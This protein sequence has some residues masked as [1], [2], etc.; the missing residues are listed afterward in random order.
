MDFIN[1]KSFS[2]YNAQVSE[3]NIETT[4]FNSEY[5]WG[6]NSLSPF[7]VTSYK[8]FKVISLKILFKNSNRNLIETDI[9]NFMAE[10]N[11]ECDFKF[12]NLSHN[13]HCFLTSPGKKETIGISRWMYLSLSLVGYE[14]ADQITEDIELVESSVNI[15]VEGNTDTPCVLEIIP[16]Q[17]VIDLVINGVSD[18]AFTVKN[19]DKDQTLIIDGENQTITV[20]SENKFLDTENFWEFPKLHPGANKIT[21]SKSYFTGKIKYKPRF[22]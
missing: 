14:Y 22:V 6:K 9:S 2:N 21:F 17:G 19:L 15:N 10:L 13:Y 18:D 8:T 3:K 7:T 1:G 5:Y 20:N 4:D 12:N 11:G 16:T